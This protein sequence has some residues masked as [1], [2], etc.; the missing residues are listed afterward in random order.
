MSFMSGFEI[1][2][3]SD[4]VALVTMN[5]PGQSVN[6]M[7]EVYARLM[8]ETLRELAD[9]IGKGRIKGI[10]LTSAKQTFFAGGDIDAILRYQ[11]EAAW[12]EC[13]TALG[14]MKRQLLRWESLGVP[15]AAA[16][17]G[18]AL[19]G[20][21]EICLACHRRVALDAPHVQLGFPEVSLGL[22]PAAGGVVRSV[23]LLGLK[24]A[25]PLLMEGTRLA[26]VK[27]KEVGLVDELA[28]DVP[29]LLQKARAWVLGN[30]GHHQPWLRKGFQIPGGNAFAAA[31]VGLLAMAPAVS[32]KK[33]RGLLPAPEA[34]LAA[35]AEGS[36]TGYEAA[37]SIESR[38]FEKLIRGPESAALIGTLYKQVNE[39][40][41]RASRPAGIA[42]SKVAKVGV[43]GAGMMGRGI[44]HACALA[45][46]AVTLKDMTPAKATAGKDHMAALLDRA[47][48]RGRLTAERRAAVL[49]LIHATAENADLADCDLVIEAVFEDIELKRRLTR[50][51]LP[52]LKSGCIF[53]SNTSTLPISLLAQAHERPEKFVGLHFFSPVDKMNLVEIIRGRQTSDATLAHAYDFVQQIRK[54]P[55]VVG[56]GRG[57][58]T[59]RVFGAFCDEGVRLLEEGVDPILIENLARQGGMPVGPLAVMD[60]V[61][62]SLMAKVS[63]TNKQLDAL[64]GENFSSVHQHMNN[65]AEAMVAEGRTG[66][67][68][69]KGFYDYRPDGSKSIAPLWRQRF[70]TSTEI[71]TDDIRDRLLFRQVVETLHCLRRGVLQTARDANVGS[72]YGW[73]FPMHTGGTMRLIEG[74]G[75][76]AFVARAAQLAARYGERFQIPDAL[77]ALLERAA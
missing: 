23:R 55:I 9:G 43:L 59:S 42:D 75:R 5:M 10:V 19:G 50:E 22:L 20:G 40:S 53:A 7:N 36:M 51:L 17:N 44:A 57:F 73:G 58:Y 34:I 3:D 37:M 52:L 61:E 65:R 2:V 41:A 33:T 26:P 70:G 68:A 1:E 11:A 25:I 48:E 4:G 14:H 47:V 28:V 54:T 66:R 63:Q 24:Q 46:I 76:Q 27:A 77:H 72:I 6:L 62:I 18:S 21:L 32:R 35:A 45:G 38:Y 71:S 13:F 29:E 69:G 8:E 49:A 64:L 39:I 67:A 31:N 15:V 30:A 16:I 74:Y 60:E 12:D 56:D